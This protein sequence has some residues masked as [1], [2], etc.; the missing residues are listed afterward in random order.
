[1]EIN[2]LS[3]IV[4]YSKVTYWVLA[5]GKGSLLYIRSGRVTQKLSWEILLMKHFNQGNQEVCY[6]W[7]WPVGNHFHSDSHQ[8]IPFPPKQKERKGPITSHIPHCPVTWCTHQ[9]MTEHTASA[10]NTPIK[11][12]RHCWASNNPS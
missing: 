12:D 6:L 5:K 3:F 4:I 9:N 10:H 7:L 1:M 11:R 2:V 8:E